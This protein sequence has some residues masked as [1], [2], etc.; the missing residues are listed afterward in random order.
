MQFL[1]GLKKGKILAKLSAQQIQEVKRQQQD[2]QVVPDHVK[3]KSVKSI[4]AH[5]MTA[6]T[7]SCH[8]PDRVTA[9]IG[10]WIVDCGL[11]DS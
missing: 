10:V 4:H 2:L 3:V 9:N 7:V 5:L 6:D 11:S 8:Q 1:L